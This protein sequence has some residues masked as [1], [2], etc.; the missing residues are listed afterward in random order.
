MLP[1]GFIQTLT[2]KVDVFLHSRHAS[3]RFLLKHVQNVYSFRKANRVDRSPRAS[4]MPG[5]NL[6]Y[7][8]PAESTQWFG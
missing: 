3:F 7:R 6:H 2:N 4:A 8:R 1:L 5:N